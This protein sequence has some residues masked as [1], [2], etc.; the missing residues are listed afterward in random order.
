MSNEERQMEVQ[1]LSS[2]TAVI[3]SLEDNS[4]LPS[5]TTHFLLHYI[6]LTAL[7]TSYYS[8]YNFKSCSSPVTAK[9]TEWIKTLSLDLRINFHFEPCKDVT[10]R[11]IV[12]VEKTLS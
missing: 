9:A 11:S 2:L 6:Y 4:P 7:V 1:F 10:G 8:D 12:I 5:H 3:K